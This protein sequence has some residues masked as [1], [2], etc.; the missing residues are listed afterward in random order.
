MARFVHLHTHSHYSLLDGLPKIPQLVAATKKRGMEALAITDHGVLYG[1]VEF[2]KAAKKAGIKPI[3]GVEAYVATN[4]LTD[5][6]ARIDDSSYHLTLL[7]ENQEGYHNLLKLVTLAHLEGFYYKPRVDHEVLRRYSG[8]LIALSGCLGGEV[9]QALLADDYEAA[10]KVALVYRSIFGEQNF[11]FEIQSHPSLTEQVKTNSGLHRLAE[12]TGISLVATKDSHYLDKEDAEAQDA[13]LCVQTGKLISDTNRLRMTATDLHFASPEEMV[14]AFPDDLA[15]VERSAEIADR[16]NV[17]LKLGTW[18]FPDFA[19][20]TGK[21]ADEYLDALAHQGLTNHFGTIAPETEERLRYELGIIKKK[22]YATYFLVV[23]DFANWTRAEGI[24]ATT[25][26]SAAGSLVAFSLGI[27]TVDPLIYRLP[28][29]RFLNEWRPTPPDIDMD[30]AD[31]RRDEVIAHVKEKYGEDRVAQIVT[32]GT[33]QARAAV[34]D[35]GRVLGYPYALCDKVAKTIPV[36][37]QGFPMSIDKALEIEP[38]LRRRY[39]TDPE[40]GRLLDLARKVEGCVRHASVHAAGV[41]ITPGPLVDFMPLQREAGGEKVIT[42]YEMHAVEDI[43]ILKMDFL[44][45]RNLAILGGA[46]KLIKK[47]YNVEINI[48]DLPLDDKKTYELLARGETIGLFQLSGSGMTRYLKELR[49]TTIHD[50]MAMVALFRP[51]PMSNIP[52]YIER[53][54]NARKI[55][56]LDPRLKSILERSYGIVTYQDDV[57][58]IAIEIAGYSWEEADTLRRAMGKKIPAVMAAEKERF[59]SGCMN[60]SKLTGPKAEELWKLIEPFAAYGF[61]KSHAASYGI[62]AYQTAYLKANYP[63]AYM[64]AVL[65]AESHNLD[66]VGEIVAECRRMGIE[67]LPPNVNESYEHFTWLDEQH[68]RFGLL[69]IKNVGEDVARALIEERKENGPFASL[70]DFLLRMQ[71]KNFNKRFLESAIKSGCLDEWGER[72]QLLNG[73]EAMLRYNR[74]A[75]TAAASRQAT[76]FGEAMNAPLPLIL[77]E[78]PPADTKQCL[79]WEREL[80]GLYVTEHPLQA[81]ASGIAPF[82]IPVGHLPFYRSDDVIGVGAVIDTVRRITTKKGDLMCFVK[83]SDATASAEII[84]FP[85]T[86]QKSPTVWE[87]DNIVLVAGKVARHE[88]EVQ[89]IADAVEVLEMEQFPDTVKRWER[90]RFQRREPEPT[91]ES[92]EEESLV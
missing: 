29:E 91:T 3:I 12:E 57:L 92:N 8:G 89:I 60:T 74:A 45:I 43:G 73:T 24:V 35:I 81:F 83:V 88:G 72:Q 82:T 34:R 61:N 56:Y 46:V 33:M 17:E 53:K 70:E 31:D 41:V 75:A 13:L 21:T 50:I 22:G 11:Y 51:G 19:I 85:S 37:S 27:T 28:F 90:L 69:A 54:H 23:A 87:P 64:T 1:V 16:C 14:A 66:K 79:T 55:T 4:R 36:G 65:R 67:V 58:L 40:V 78:V 47:I 49:P 10:R 76:L 26:G 15:A 6:R 30:F 59:I 42:Q 18:I 32:F 20:P 7:A 5:K 52:Q 2:Y 44:G 25:R 38:E 80:L 77:E 62:V 86:Y 71:T 48:N 63:C 39:E 84:V 9:A 68:I